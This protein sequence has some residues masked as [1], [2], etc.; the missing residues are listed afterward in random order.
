M[1]REMI[2]S[3]VAQLY[4][5]SFECSRLEGAALPRKFL[6]SKTLDQK[7]RELP[8]MKLIHLARMTDST[9]VFQHAIFSVPNFSEGLLHR[10]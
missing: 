10:R 6:A 8:P 1:G 5:R 4:M 9:G 2:W 7:P 3:N